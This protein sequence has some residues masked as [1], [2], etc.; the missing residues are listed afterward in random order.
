[1]SPNMKTLKKIAGA[2][3]KPAGKLRGP[4][5]KAVKGAKMNGPKRRLSPK[6]Y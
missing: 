3:N 5:T 4:L 2:K 6:V 1:M